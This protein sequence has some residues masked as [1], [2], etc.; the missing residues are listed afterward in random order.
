[1]EILDF[2]FFNRE[3]REFPRMKRRNLERIEILRI[4]CSKI[5]E[6][7]VDSRLNFQILELRIKE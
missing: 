3:F 7:R 2:G 1:L 6:I 5:R 4:H